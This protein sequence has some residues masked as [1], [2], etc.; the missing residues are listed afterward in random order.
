MAQHS[1]LVEDPDLVPSNHTRQL[2]NSY[3]DVTLMKQI[4][5]KTCIENLIQQVFFQQSYIRSSVFQADKVHFSEK[6]DSSKK[7]NFGLI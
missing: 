7:D 2:T 4:M 6:L 1:P 5:L 3:W